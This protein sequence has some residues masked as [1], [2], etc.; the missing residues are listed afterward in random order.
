MDKL[1]K[2]KLHRYPFST[3]ESSPTV[4]NPYKQAKYKISLVP[5]WNNSWLPFLTVILPGEDVLGRRSRSHCCYSVV[6][7]TG[8]NQ[9]DTLSW[10]WLFVFSFWRIRTNFKVITED[11]R[12]GPKQAR[13]NLTEKTTKCYI[14]K[15]NY[16]IHKLCHEYHWL[17]TEWCCNN[18]WS[19]QTK[20][21]ATEQENACH[22]KRRTMCKIHKV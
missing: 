5:L 19:S 12:S 11:W 22:V 14:R 18:D 2:S 21:E 10:E 8:E 3:K 1:K 16:I 20:Y 17:D 4:T 13:W 9:W 7:C 6:L 15:G